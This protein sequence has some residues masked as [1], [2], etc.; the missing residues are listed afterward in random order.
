MNATQGSKARDLIDA[1]D[2]TIVR[3]DVAGHAPGG[4]STHTDPHINFTTPS[5]RTP[6]ANQSTHGA[7]EI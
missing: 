5:I 6:R 7:N 2:G 4:I 3:E 1:S